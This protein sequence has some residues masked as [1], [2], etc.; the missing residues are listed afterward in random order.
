MEAITSGIL[1]WSILG[2][3]LFNVFIN[4]VENRTEC[5]VIKFTDCTKLRGVAD[6]LCGWAAFHLDKLKNWADR[7]LMKLEKRKYQFL[8]LRRSNLAVSVNA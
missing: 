5:T 3:I 8:H 4:D 6:K 7:N 1:Q 2:E